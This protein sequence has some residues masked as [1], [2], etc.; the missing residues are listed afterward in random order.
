MP[1]QW[2]WVFRVQARNK[3]ISIGLLTGLAGFSPKIR[4][5]LV[6]IFKSAEALLDPLQ[7]FRYRAIRWSAAEHKPARRQAPR[8]E[9][10]IEIPKQ[11]FTDDRGEAIADS[12]SIR[13]VLFY[14]V[15]KLVNG[16]RRP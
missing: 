16:D 13:L 5:H 3:I 7:L 11:R 9:G 15:S 4:P 12:D 10:A 6:R 1:E 2:I 8:F 14:G